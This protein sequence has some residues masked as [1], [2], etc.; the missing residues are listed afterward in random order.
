MKK[1]EKEIR[2]FKT[3][4]ELRNNDENTSRHIC[5]YAVRFN[6][7]SRYIGW[8]ET[9]AP[10]AITEETLRSSDIFMT[11]DHRDDNFLARSRFGEG[12]LKLELREDGLYFDF[13]CPDT[14]FGNDIMSK[15]LRGELDECSFAFSIDPED[16]TADTWCRE[17]DGR[18]CRTINHI[19][20]LYDCSIVRTGAY[21]TTSVSKRAQDK[22]EQLDAEVLASLQE[23]IDD[24]NNIEAQFADVT[25][26]EE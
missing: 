1:M 11:F 19:A 10:T 24:M 26:T 3:N 12:T 17:A 23:R 13:E 16:N 14:A 6:E 21:G 18:T 7:Q 9:I 20:R 2:S 15:V 8:Y 4:L 22:I 5:G 25:G